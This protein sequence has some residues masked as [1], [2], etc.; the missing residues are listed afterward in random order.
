MKRDAVLDYA[1]GI[2]IILMVIGHCYSE[3][4]IVL[5]L[6]YGFHMAFFFIVSGIIYGRKTESTDFRF[7]PLKTVKN[8]LIPYFIYELLFSAFISLLDRNNGFVHSMAGKAISIIT[9]KGVTATWYLSCIVFVELIFLGLYQKIKLRI[10]PISAGLFVLGLFLAPY[11]KNYAVV[12][13]RVMIAMG[14]FAFGFVLGR[15]IQKPEH[16]KVVYWGLPVCAL[17][18]YIT[19]SYNGMVSLVSLKLSNPVLYVCNAVLGTF[20][21]LMISLVVSRTSSG[22]VLNKILDKMGKNTLF[23]LGTHMLL[24]EVIRLL[25]FKLLGEFFPKLGLGEGIVFGL[26]VCFAEYMMIPFYQHIKSGLNQ[27]FKEC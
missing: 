22:N 4:N 12:P 19:A 26:I 16:S 14:F 27:K 24:V 21:L 10:L 20:V 17:L 15:K 7:S 6:I 3:E 11:A 5:T 9:F 2:A 1:K 8:L 13:V 18:Y 23:I 25:D